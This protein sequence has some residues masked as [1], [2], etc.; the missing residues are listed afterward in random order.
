MPP[1]GHDSAYSLELFRLPAKQ[2]LDHTRK[3]QLLDVFELACMLWIETELNQS[4][5]IYV[6]CDLL[7]LCVTV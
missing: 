2:Q 7:H 3:S 4:I 1:H 6:V 5:N